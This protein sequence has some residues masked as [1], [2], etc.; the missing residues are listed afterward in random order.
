[1]GNSVSGM[2]QTSQTAMKAPA[3]PLPGCGR[4]WLDMLQ[5]GYLL[6]RA[7]LRRE[8]GPAGDLEEAYRRWYA[9]QMDEHDQLVAKVYDRLHA[10]QAAGSH[11]S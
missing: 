11:G 3:Q 1:M 10:K 4:A 6:L 7:G 9:E 2:E 8:T 5:A